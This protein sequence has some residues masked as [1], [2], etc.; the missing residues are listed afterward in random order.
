MQLS[1]RSDKKLTSH[2]Y[3]EKALMRTAWVLY[4]KP[5][6]ESKTKT[7]LAKTTGDVFALELYKLIL[8]WQF[9]NIAAIEKFTNSKAIVYTNYL[10]EKPKMVK[11][12]FLETGLSKNIPIREQSAGSLGDKMINT[13]NELMQEGFDNVVIWGADILLLHEEHFRR[14][15]DN[16]P[17]SSIIPADDG[18]YCL[19]SFSKQNFDNDAMLNIPWST[20]H[21]LKYQIKNLEKLGIDYDTFFKIPDLDLGIDIQKNLEY[22]QDHPSAIYQKRA[23]D[24]AA[25]LEVF[26]CTKRDINNLESS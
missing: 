8:Q 14:V 24:L 12:L 13:F 17:K 19:I 15:A 22:M 2:L 21:T 11:H 20:E 7:R 26:W 1:S 10:Q 9:E 16:F 3:Y 25:L 5:P 4:A 23:S 6:I 18:G